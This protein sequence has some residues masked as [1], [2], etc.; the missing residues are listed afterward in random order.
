MSDDG[1]REVKFNQEH[2]DLLMKCAEKKDMTEWNEWCREYR[3]GL[4]DDYGLEEGALLESA[5]L[6][7]INLQGAD[8]IDAHL[9]GADLKWS[10]LD[11]ANLFMSHLEGANLYQAHLMSTSFRCACLDGQTSFMDCRYNEKTDF[12]ATAIASTRIEPNILIKLQYNIR[13][14]QW[15]KWYVKPRV[16][17]LM[18]SLS[19]KWKKFRGVAYE[20]I[21]KTYLSKPTEEIMKLTGKKRLK[22]IFLDLPTEI[23]WWI[24]DYGQNTKRII[25]TFFGLNA[26]FTILYMG[27]SSITPHI[28][29]NTVPIFNESVSPL[30]AL[31][32]SNMIVFSITDVATRNLDEITMFFVLI[33]I[34]LGYV[35]LAALVT[36]F[37]IMFQ[38][39]GR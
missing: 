15:E 31:M 12:T 32:Q 16:Y 30:M 25:G 24:S 36:R 5:D 7:K 22:S 19:N 23:F 27:L 14:A 37:A 38:S 18:A 17:P 10:N 11:G 2:Y 29:P 33:H 20:E 3:Q 34:I 1:T 21:P 9:E 6:V 4:F 28:M 8:L 13:R 35:L 39:V 26:L